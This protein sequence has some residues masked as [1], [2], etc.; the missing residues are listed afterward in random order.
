MSESSSRAFPMS[1]DDLLSE[2]RPNIHFRH[3]TPDSQIKNAGV[4]ID[5]YSARLDVF[6]TVINDASPI[7]VDPFLHAM[8]RMST[9]ANGYMINAI[10]KRLNPGG[11]YLNVGTFEGFTFFCGMAGNETRHCIGVD[12]FSQFG[13]P[14]EKFF[15]GYRRYKSK[16]S[17]FYNMDYVKYFK[18]YHKLPIGFYVYDG[19]HDYDNQLNGLKV[20]EPF[21][22]SDTLILVDDTNDDVVR[23]ATLDFIAGRTDKYR[24]LLDE[25]TAGN[26]HPTFW[27]GIMLIG[28]N[29]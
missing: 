2:I 11:V 20:A 23:N 19:P 29:G 18:D 6:N 13:G 10:T 21:F 14:R 12:N 8:T 7:N 5:T 27:N 16:K 25:K 4:V 15:Q 26:E 28:H 3:F 1:H 24:I 22:S 9:I 17:E